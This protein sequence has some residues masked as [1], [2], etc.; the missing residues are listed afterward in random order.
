MQTV[1]APSDRSKPRKTG[2]WDS[3]TKDRAADLRKRIDESLDTLAKAVDEVRASDTFRQFLDVQARF[4]RYSWHNTLL[5][6][7]QRPDATRVAGY[8]AWQKLKR[9]VCKGERGIMIF[10]PC[11][12]HREVEKSEGGTESIDGVYFRAV[13]VFDI[14]QTDGEA[15]PTLE[16]PTVDAAADGLLRRLVSVAQARKIEVVLDRFRDGFFGV[17][18]H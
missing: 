7:S 13:Y 17:S 12:F 6:A 8:R 5:I 9:Q 2:N 15:L 14:A 3:S 18:K 16:V 4:H 10:A 11:P 1:S